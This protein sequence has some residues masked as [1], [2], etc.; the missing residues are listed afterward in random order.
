MTPLVHERPAGEHPATSSS[1]LEHG[2]QCSNRNSSSEN[3]HGIFE[4]GAEEY[5]KCPFL[6]PETVI[7]MAAAGAIGLTDAAAALPRI[8]GNRRSL[9]IK[10]LF[11][12]VGVLCGVPIFVPTISCAALVCTPV[13]CCRRS[14]CPFQNTAPT[15]CQ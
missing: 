5:K 8:A 14:V 4:K 12:A 7:I 15:L 1:E 11:R 3:Y 2:H 9:L 10:A 6:S 13:L